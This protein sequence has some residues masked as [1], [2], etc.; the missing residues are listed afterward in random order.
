MRKD[1]LRLAADIRND[2]SNAAGSSQ[3]VAQLGTSAT[4]AT[5]VRQPRMR[6]TPSPSGSS[7]SSG[8][9]SAG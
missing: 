4:S 5:A 7:S 3:E 8:R 9:A 6:R 1:V 2:H